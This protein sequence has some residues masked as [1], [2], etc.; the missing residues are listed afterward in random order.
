MEGKKV[1]GQISLYQ[2]SIRRVRGLYLLSGDGICVN[3]DNVREA[4]EMFL[5]VLSPGVP[6]VLLVWYQQRLKGYRE[7]CYIFQN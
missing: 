6:R 2:R 7:K 1:V 4:G 3:C 5:P